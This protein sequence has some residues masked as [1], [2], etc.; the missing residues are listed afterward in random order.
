MIEQTNQS[1]VSMLFN[2]NGTIDNMD[3]L[4]LFAEFMNI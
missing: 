3:A 2:K 4:K 1:M